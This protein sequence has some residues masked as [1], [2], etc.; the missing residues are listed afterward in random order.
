MD[1]QVDGLFRVDSKGRVLKS[2]ER[3]NHR[4]N[5]RIV[6]QL[7][8]RPPEEDWSPTFGDPGCRYRTELISLIPLQE[9]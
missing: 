1:L 4:D 8:C 2:K 6:Y 7:S 3:M 9:H 5:E